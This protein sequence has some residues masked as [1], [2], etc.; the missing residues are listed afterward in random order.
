MMGSSH[1]VSVLTSVWSGL[2]CS[3]SI[4]H[5]NVRA[6]RVGGDGTGCAQVLTAREAIAECFF[7][8]AET[9]VTAA[10]HFSHKLLLQRRKTSICVVPNG[11]QLSPDLSDVEPPELAIPYNMA[12]GRGGEMGAQY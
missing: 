12:S 2:A 6:G 8:E 9:L 11:A 5:R 10:V 3:C 4:N 1:E 7:D